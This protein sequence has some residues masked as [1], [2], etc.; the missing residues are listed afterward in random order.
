MDVFPQ[1]LFYCEER[2]E[3]TMGLEARLLGRTKIYTD[4]TIIDEDNILSVLRKAY[5]KHLFNRRQM[6]FLIDYEGGQQPL[7]RQKIVR[8][9]ID[10]KVNGS[11][12]NYVKE[13]KIGYNWS[14]PI[15]LV[16]RGD[17]EMHDSDSKTDVIKISV[18]QSLLK[19]AV[20]VIE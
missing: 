11:V 5:A 9:D 14:S 7:K 1:M 17:K 8:P 19:S 6:Q 20:S 12:A 16:Q 2:G 18:W 4:E 13:F 15:M 3:T 10:I